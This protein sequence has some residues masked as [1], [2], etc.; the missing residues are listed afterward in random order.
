MHVFLNIPILNEYGNLPA[1]LL[2]IEKQSDKDFSVFFCVN[3]ADNC[4][5]DEKKGHIC[6]DNAKSLKLLYSFAERVDFPVFIIDRS[7]KTK[8]WINKDQGVGHARREL[9]DFSSNRAEEKDIILSL[10]ADTQIPE[11]Y[12]AQVRR[13]F[14]IFP[15]AGALSIP[16]Y[17]KSVGD[18]FM[19]KAILRYEMYM[20]YY[21]LNLL[22]IKSPYAYTAIGS[23]MACTVKAYRRIGGL[24]PKIS[25]EDFYFMMQLRKTGALLPWCKTIVYP[26]SRASDRVIFGTGT[27][28]KYGLLNDWTRYI[29]YDLEAY[30]RIAKATE[31]F[32]SYFEIESE[33]SRDIIL[34]VF[35]DVEL[36]KLRKNHPNKERFVHACHEK[37]DSLAI[38]QTLKRLHSQKYSDS[39]NLMRFCS[40]YTESSPFI[41]FS[42]EKSS[43]NDYLR[44]RDF[45]FE[46]ET[47][48]LKK[49]YEKFQALVKEK[50]HSIWK[51][52][53]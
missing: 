8:G 44:M 39:E 25:G 50:G 20:R 53:S 27:A 40:K 23:A 24:A 28:V 42:F 45:L 35:P 37:A 48:I 38:L 41:D 32:S 22:R 51:Y 4:W 47:E 3:Q 30:D 7:S 31:A 29:F 26:S 17:H 36:K 15:K 46:K 13:T 14:Q 6:E 52:M 33:K 16:F 43:L 21:L 12:I 19:Q 5:D 34:S 1:L 2:D 9:M 49:Q 10:D 18:E 11:A